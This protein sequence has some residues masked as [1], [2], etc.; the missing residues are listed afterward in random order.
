MG[1]AL[2]L[3]VGLLV[4]GG[5]TLVI[6]SRR[7]LLKYQHTAD[8]LFALKHRWTMSSVE[9]ASLKFWPELLQRLDKEDKPPLADQTPVFQL[10]GQIPVVLRLNDWNC[11]MQW[12]DESAAVNV[13]HMLSVL[14]REKA[15]QLVQSLIPPKSQ[16]SLIWEEEQPGVTKKRKPLRIWDELFHVENNL[17][18]PVATREITLWNQGP[19]N[20][21]R[22]REETLTALSQQVVTSQRSQDW[23]AAWKQRKPGQSLLEIW[24]AQGYKAEDVQLLQRLF[25]EESSHASLW[26]NDPVTHDQTLFITRIGTGRS[27]DVQVYR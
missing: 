8:D 23:L 20:V 5:V 17:S 13:N 7:A 21:H 3:V 16:P 10:P 26:L 11:Q 2:I 25:S 22:A 6:L 27:V 15:H 19:L 14:K 4:V 18:L 12:R 1:I 9:Q 24:R